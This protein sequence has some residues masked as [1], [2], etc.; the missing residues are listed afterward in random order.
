[1]VI[2]RPREDELNRGDLLDGI[3]DVRLAV[4]EPLEVLLGRLPARN[5]VEIVHEFRLRRRADRLDHWPAVR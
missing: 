1:V 2:R 4:E 5:S 3:E